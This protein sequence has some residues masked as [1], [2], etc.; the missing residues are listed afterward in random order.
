LQ[1]DSIQTGDTSPTLDTG[2]MHLI[3]SYYKSPAWQPERVSAQAPLPRQKTFELIPFFN[4]LNL[5]AKAEAPQELLTP[6]QPS[7][8]LFNLTSI[9][10]SLNLCFAMI[11]ML[12]GTD[13]W[14]R[15]G[16]FQKLDNG[17]RRSNP[18]NLYAQRWR[19]S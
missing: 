17:F 14:S 2:N 5:G 8:I 16:C 9:Q 6:A 3:D 15:A 19:L 12:I 1:V 13:L 10:L 11:S 4:H 18:K 7:M